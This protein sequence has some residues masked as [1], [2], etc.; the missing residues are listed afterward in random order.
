MIS[1]S[2]RV[3]ALLLVLLPGLLLAGC[4]STAT[5][6]SA[7]GAQ[8]S[9]KAIASAV[10]S[11]QGKTAAP[12]AAGPITT[13]EQLCKL[14]PVADAQGAVAAT[15]VLT[16]QTPGKFIDDEPGCGYSSVG[17]KVILSVFL[18]P[19]KA[20]PFTGTRPIM[21]AGSLTA[22]PGLGEKA[23][24]NRN[25]LDILKGD[26]VISIE[27]AGPTDLTKDQLIAAGKLFASRL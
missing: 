16:E 15:P 22:V 27:T 7:S 8:A 20:N 14:V 13:G 6:A 5:P 1:T 25:E 4:S 11:A 17:A 3:G 21:S 2:R 24:V 19:L 26:I 9:A 23:G 18:F 12:V 10:A